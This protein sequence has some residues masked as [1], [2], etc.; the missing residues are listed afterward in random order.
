[1]HFLNREGGDDGKFR[2]FYVYNRLISKGEK[3]SSAM[4]QGV[5]DEDIA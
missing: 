3:G 4:E 2:C 1:M 5:R